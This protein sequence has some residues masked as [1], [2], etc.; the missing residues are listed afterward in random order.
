MQAEARDFLD[1]NNV[2]C[3]VVTIDRGDENPEIHR[4]DYA[5]MSML[6]IKAPI[7]DFDAF[8][9]WVLSAG[10]GDCSQDTLVQAIT[11]YMSQDKNANLLSAA[12]L[13]QNSIAPLLAGIY[14]KDKLLEAMENARYTQRA[15]NE[16]TELP[17]ALDVWTKDKTT[18]TVQLFEN[19]TPVWTQRL[20]HLQLVGREEGMP[21]DN[22]CALSVGRTTRVHNVAV[23]GGF[24]E[25]VSPHLLLLAII[26]TKLNSPV[27]KEAE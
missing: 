24:L 11:G 16:K 14:P 7:L 21:A 9:S 10:N 3:T 5:L 12:I 4:F 8:E 13:S 19:E 26:E 6:K 17:E 22:M 20:S 1:V 25:S 18:V 27:Q 2:T 15:F 23:A